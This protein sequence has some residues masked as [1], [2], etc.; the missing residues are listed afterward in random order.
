MDPLDS[1]GLRRDPFS[2]EIEAGLPWRLFV[3][4]RVCVAL[5][6][7]AVNTPWSE[8]GGCSVTSAYRVPTDDR[9]LFVQQCR[10]PGDRR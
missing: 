3:D 2:P 7:E 9:H 4:K 1:F 6:S 8:S 10:G 5:P